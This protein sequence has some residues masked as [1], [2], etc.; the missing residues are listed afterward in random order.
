MSPKVLY[1]AR[2]AEGVTVAK[3][4]IPNGRWVWMLAPSGEHDG[5]VGAAPRP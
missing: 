2:R 4:R 3:E 1:A 5:E